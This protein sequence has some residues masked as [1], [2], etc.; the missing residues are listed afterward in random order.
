MK[1][2]RPAILFA[3]FVPA[4]CSTSP[5][6]LESQ[7]TSALTGPVA[8]TSFGPNPVRCGCG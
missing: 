6:D 7:A 3:A 5:V 4:A 1:M 2:S 8:V